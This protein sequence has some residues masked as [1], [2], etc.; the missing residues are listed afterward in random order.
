MPNDE[1]KIED[2]AGTKVT[3]KADSEIGRGVGGGRWHDNKGGA[4]WNFESAYLQ[5]LY[6]LKPG[7]LE[8]TQ[9]CT[10]YC[11]VLV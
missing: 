7:E 3:N 8:R 11:T 9:Y 5:G 4:L 10:P 6:P 1:R 2:D